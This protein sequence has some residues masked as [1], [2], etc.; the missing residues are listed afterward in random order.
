MTKEDVKKMILNIINGSSGIKAT[1]L[2]T[3][4]YDEAK[5]HSLE[6]HNIVVYVEEL[7]F[8]NEI[9]E[10]EYTLPLMSYRL[11]SIY[12]PIGTTIKTING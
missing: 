1:E 8:E 12:F 10:I 6:E 7:V 3:A 9:L 5:E 2:I 11:K 4:V